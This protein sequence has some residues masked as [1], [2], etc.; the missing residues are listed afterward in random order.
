MVHLGPSSLINPCLPSSRQCLSA[1]GGG[2]MA[3]DD[4][5]CLHCCRI[6]NGVARHNKALRTNNDYN[7]TINLVTKDDD[8][9]KTAKARA[10]A[11]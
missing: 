11:G 4:V 8:A 6:P 7:A 5:A 2:A 3:G 10:A 1:G 9:D